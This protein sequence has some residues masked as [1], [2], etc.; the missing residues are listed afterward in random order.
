MTKQ[1]NYGRT[2]KTIK[3]A[4]EKIRETHADVETIAFVFLCLLYSVVTMK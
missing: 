2:K 4:K 1:T 3:R